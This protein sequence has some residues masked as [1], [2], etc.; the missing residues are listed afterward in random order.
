MKWF[1]QYEPLL[2]LF[3]YGAPELHKV[4]NRYLTWAATAAVAFD[5][6]MVGSWLGGRLLS[7]EPE[8]RLVRLRVI[9]DVAELGPPPSIATPTQALAVRG[10]LVR[11]SVGVPVP[12]PDALITPEATLAT[13]E[14]MAQMQAP[15]GT[16]E[17][18]GDSMVVAAD[19][20]LYGETLE[21]PGINE[22]IPFEMPPMVVKRVEPVY[23][24]LARKAGMQG[25]VVVKALVDK[26]GQVKK[27]A[28]I[29]G[30]EIFHEAAIQAVML[31][32]FKP[33]LQQNKPVMVWVAIPLNFVLKE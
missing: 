29:Q 30:H 31:W 6:V 13:Q 4:Y 28:V 2:Q 15:V 26:N 10:P 32:V 25:K 24:E 5:L 8:V 22:F 1:W 18:G 7:R 21:E 16:G 9:R 12:V 17:S 11:P 23:P 33:A 14:E 19:A 3:P 20:V 27:V